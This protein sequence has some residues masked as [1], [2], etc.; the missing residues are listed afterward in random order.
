VAQVE[1]SLAGGMKQPNSR[2]IEFGESA[3]IRRRMWSWP[4][5]GL[6]MECR[7]T[8]RRHCPI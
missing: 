7:S 5:A 4:P 8:T 3:R 6:T 2:C 1:F